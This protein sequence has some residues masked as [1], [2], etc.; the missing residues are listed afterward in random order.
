MYPRFT[1][2]NVI[3][4]ETIKLVQQYARSGYAQKLLE[5]LNVIDSV[6]RDVAAGDGFDLEVMPFDSAAIQ[7]KYPCFA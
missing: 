3:N 4:F 7:L 1:F 5:N 6:W 2:G